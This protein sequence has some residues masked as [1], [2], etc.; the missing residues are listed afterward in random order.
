MSN[1]FNGL[2]GSLSPQPAGLET[3]DHDDDG[4]KE[5]TGLLSRSRHS[6][7]V[8]SGDE[9]EDD[10]TASREAEE[11][12]HQRSAGGVPHSLYASSKE[13]VLQRRQGSATSSPSKGWVIGRFGSFGTSRGRGGG[14]G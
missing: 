8:D 4:S 14:D 5:H 12:G 7:K 13:P 10:I 6:H 9:H 2:F 1:A 3:D 11:F